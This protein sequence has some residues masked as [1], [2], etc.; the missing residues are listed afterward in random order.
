MKVKLK[1]PAVLVK[2]ELTIEEKMKKM[3]KDRDKI[4]KAFSKSNKKGVSR[5]QLFQIDKQMNQAEMQNLYL[6][7]QLLQINK[8]IDTFI[9]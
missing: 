9:T 2:K 5:F 1:K 3:E 7:N 4:S 8:K 6:R